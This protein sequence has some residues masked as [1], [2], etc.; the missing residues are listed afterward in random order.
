MVANI[1]LIGSSPIMLPT[2]NSIYPINAPYHSTRA[3]CAANEM[4]S[5]VSMNEMIDER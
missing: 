1:R 5:E 2:N 3:P 4:K